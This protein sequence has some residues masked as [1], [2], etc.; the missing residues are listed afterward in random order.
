MS[1]RTFTAYC[2][3][4]FGK[5]KLCTSH[6][7]VLL[8]IILVSVMIC[9]RKG[10][11]AVFLVVSIFFHQNTYPKNDIA[12]ATFYATSDERLHQMCDKSCHVSSSKRFL[13]NQEKAC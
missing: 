11:F 1:S 4:Y 8:S 3:N 7:R 6:F 9:R 10:D 5:C 12:M 2:L 13:I